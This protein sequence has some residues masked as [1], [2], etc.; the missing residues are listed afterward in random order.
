VQRSSGLAAVAGGLTEAGKIVSSGAKASK[1]IL[2]Q[3][4][5]KNQR[6]IESM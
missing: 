4:A 6:E 1:V 3:A 5:A 2:S